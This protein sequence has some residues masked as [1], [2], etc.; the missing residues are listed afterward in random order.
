MSD[1][2]VS[3]SALRGEAQHQLAEYPSGPVGLTPAE[4]LALVE[5]V[6]AAHA[7]VETLEPGEMA[8]DARLWEALSRFDF[9]GET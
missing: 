1:G 7:L 2:R 9:G 6:E 4:V 5:A 8:D 3:V